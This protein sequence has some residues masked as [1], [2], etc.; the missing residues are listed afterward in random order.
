MLAQRPGTDRVLPVLILAPRGR[1]AA[2]VEQVLRAAGI[3]T[4]ACA[5]LLELAAG[6]A[7]CSAVVVTEEALAG[8]H[9]S[10]L[11]H[12]VA[13][14]PPWSDLAFLVLATKQRGVRTASRTGILD[15]LG[16]PVLLE[17][18][19]NAE[20]LVSAA[21]S[22]LRA[23]GRQLAVRDLTAGLEDRVRERTAALTESEARSRAI[24]EGF[25]ECLF[26]VAVSAAGSSPWNGSIPWQRAAPR[27]DRR[28]SADARWMP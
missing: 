4:L 13:A 12:W 9:L 7:D 24:F 23:R 11:L 16:N 8:Q 14:Q 5:G 6:L 21:R 10:G 26:I 20:S 15:R 3:A 22:A 27:W 17:R 1:D 18:P 2:V 25:P 28:R 19:L